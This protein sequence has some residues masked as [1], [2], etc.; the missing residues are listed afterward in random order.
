MDAEQVRQLLESQQ[1]LIEAFIQ[2]QQQAQQQ[3]SETY[4]AI[5]GRVWIRKFGLDS[6]NLDTHAT[7]VSTVKL[8]DTIENMDQVPQMYPVL[9]SGKIGKIPDVVVSLK[10][11]KRAQPVFHRERDVPYVPQAIAIDQVLV[12]Y[13]PDLPVQ[14][15]CDAS[16]TRIA[17]VLSHIVDGNEHPITFASQSLTAAEQNYSQ[18]DREALAII[19]TVDPFYQY[20][21]GLHFKLVTNNQPLTRIF[22]HRAALPMMTA[23]HLQRYAAFLSGFNY[24]IDF[25]KGIE[26]SNVD[27]LSRAPININSYTASAISNEVS[28][29]VVLPSNKSASR[30]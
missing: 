10:L 16:P 12:P 27:C 15:V 14:L 19:F 21:Y 13:D 8:I 6:H 9:C 1:R 29:S 7:D 11:Q 24:T 2:S 17:G 22:N 3:Q 18:F 20:L 5:A 30:L 25:K 28:S 4:D 26:N 23:G